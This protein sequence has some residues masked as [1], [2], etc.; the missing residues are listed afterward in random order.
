MAKVCAE[1]LVWFAAALLL[2]LRLPHLSV[3]VQLSEIQFETISAGPQRLHA[4]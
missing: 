2:H 1:L 4:H 3:L